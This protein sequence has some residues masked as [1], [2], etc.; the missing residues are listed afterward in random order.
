MVS[1]PDAHYF[2]RREQSKLFYQGMLLLAK[3]HYN[4]YRTTP[5]ASLQQQKTVKINT[6]IG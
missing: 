5:H 1:V 3:K 2:Q 4:L 6:K